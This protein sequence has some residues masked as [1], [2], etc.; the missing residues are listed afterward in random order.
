MVYGT[1][2]DMLVKKYLSENGY[3]LNDAT[4]Y[5]DHESDISLLKLVSK[6]YIANPNAH[7]QSLAKR[8]NL[9]I[10]DLS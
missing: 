8:Y 1:N 7:M 4:A 5:A 9:G 6:G 3:D 2:K 10:I